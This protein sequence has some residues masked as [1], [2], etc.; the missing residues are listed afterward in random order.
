MTFE[1]GPLTTVNRSIH[2][3]GEGS[4]QLQPEPSDVTASR[5][6]FFH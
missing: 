1:I 3:E 6:C 4:L 2:L 5:S